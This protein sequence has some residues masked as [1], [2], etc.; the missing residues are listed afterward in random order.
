MINCDY[1]IIFKLKKEKI[2]KNKTIDVYVQNFFGPNSHI[3]ILL[4]YESNESSYYYIINRWALPIHNFLKINQNFKNNC[5]NKAGSNFHFQINADPNVIASAWCTKYSN[6]ASHANIITENCAD[7]AEWFL[8]RFAKIPKTRSSSNISF[9]HVIFGIFWPSFLPSFITLPGR[10]FSNAKFYISARK[11]PMLGF[12]KILLL[13][14]VLF[15]SVAMAIGSVIAVP[16]A[17]KYTQLPHAFI[18]AL[19]CLSGIIALKIFRHTH[20]ALLADSIQKED[21]NSNTGIGLA[22]KIFYY[23]VMVKSIL[24][25]VSAAAA[26]YMFYRFTQIS[27][28]LIVILG[29]LSLGFSLLILRLSINVLFSKSDDPE[30]KG[31]QESEALRKT[32]GASADQVGDMGLSLGQA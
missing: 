31:V 30:N 11:K 18:I 8:S 6:T 13:Y 5:I 9:N 20:N 26:S 21:P 14:T 28:P 23:F 10:V 17:F 12:G 29:L 32:S 3:E 16:L 27:K 25:A 1:S 15:L 22:A 2:L 19:A 24:M 4:T 7:A